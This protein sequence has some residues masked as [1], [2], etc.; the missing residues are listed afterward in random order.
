MFLVIYAWFNRKYRPIRAKNLA[1]TT[2]IHIAGILWFLGDVVTNG[3]VR[4]KGVF[5]HCKLWII[6]F[7]ILFCYMYASM[8]IVRFYALDRVFNQNKPFRGRTNLYAI[9]FVIVFNVG[10]CLVS[11]LVKTELTVYQSDV[12]ELCDVDINYRIA[13]ITIQW[14]MWAGVAVLIYR[15]R[16]I[17]SSFNEF[18]ESLG[19]FIIAIIVLIDTSVNNFA[20]PRYPLVL[21]HRLEKTS[22]DVLGANIMVW[23]ILA[24]PVYNCMFHRRQYESG[25]LAKLT[26]DGHKKE[27][28]VSSGQAGLTTAY[29]KMNESEFQDTRLNFSGSDGIDPVYYANNQNYYDNDTL[30]GDATLRNPEVYVNQDSIP[31]AL[32]TNLHIHRPVLNTPSMFRTVVKDNA[33]DNR[34]VV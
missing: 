9:A 15:L 7:R 6:W 17:Q 1:W 28:E 16:N 4:I 14:V 30:A 10:F 18:R 33:A 20:L 8:L 3:H 5:G 31:I 11:H 23:L 22:I 2:A 29:A 25:W 13:A 12:L 34:R 32:R 21:K 24:Q 19:L 26:K 27:Y